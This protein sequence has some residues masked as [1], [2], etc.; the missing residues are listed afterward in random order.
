MRRLVVHT[1]AKFLPFHHKKLQPLSRK[2]SSCHFRYAGGVVLQW[3]C[4]ARF[5]ALYLIHFQFLDQ[6]FPRASA[7][8]IRSYLLVQVQ[9]LLLTHHHSDRVV[10]VQ[11]QA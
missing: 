2:V 6:Q 10:L 5:Q 1:L 3:F 11:I 7:D 8:A 4:C 9:A